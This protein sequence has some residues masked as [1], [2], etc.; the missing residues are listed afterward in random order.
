LTPRFVRLY[1][2]L[3]TLITPMTMRGNVLIRLTPA[4]P[5]F[6]L[7]LVA[8]MLWSAPVKLQVTAEQANIREKPDI[9][10][11]ILLQ[12]PEGTVLDAEQK[13]GEWYAVRITQ[14]EGQFVNGFVHESLVRVVETQEERP[15]KKET[16]K[17]NPPEVKL[18]EPAP[19]PP[20]EKPPQLPPEVPVEPE[21][22]VVS[23]W[24]GGRYASVGDFNEGTRGL[25]QLYEDR[26]GVGGK[27]EVDSLHLGYL[28]GLDA[29][30]PLARRFFFTVGAEYYRGERSSS[31]SYQTEAGALYTAKPRVSAV[32]ITVGLSFYPLPYGYVKIGVDYTFGRCSYF[33]RFEEGD[34]WE[35]REGHAS[36]GGFGYQVGLGADLRVF[37]NVFVAA[38]AIYHHSRLT[39]LEGEN[40]Y[41]RSDGVSSHEE[42][43]LYYFRV[44]ENG[45]DLVPLVLVLEGRPADIGGYDERVAE[46]SL[47]GLSLRAGIRVRF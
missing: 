15:E 37:R 44:S 41:R 14:E 33:Y 43:R 31:V 1:N 38:E 7:L 24:L 32:P 45:T 18:E 21:P 28:F 39:N 19:P 5:L 20:P 12:V 26:L 22:F 17:E 10:S 4:S 8:A 36:S 47:S 9:S 6:L 23:L 30:L 13:E 34:F 42:G 40:I 3:S 46:L 2:L 27:G 29:Q 35:E 11:A 25:A 16:V